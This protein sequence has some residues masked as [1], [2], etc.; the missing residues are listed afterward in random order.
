MADQT[1]IQALIAALTGSSPEVVTQLRQALAAVPLAAAE[2]N[3][4]D[5]GHEWSDMRKTPSGVKVGRSCKKC[6]VLAA[7]TG[8]A[9]GKLVDAESG[10]APVSEAVAAAVSGDAAP[11]VPKRDRKKKTA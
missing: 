8:H 6:G 10:D 4:C 9:H 7:I 2:V 1:Q 3:P 5:H 11:S